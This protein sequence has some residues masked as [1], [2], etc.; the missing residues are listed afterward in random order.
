MP[1][2]EW[3]AARRKDIGKNWGKEKPSEPAQLTANGSWTN[4]L[5]A[6][7]S[8]TGSYY[9]SAG[10]EGVLSITAASFG[11]KDD[12]VRGALE[13]FDIPFK[14][15]SEDKTTRKGIKFTE[16]EFSLNPESIQMV[17]DKLD[18]LN[19][20]NMS[21]EYEKIR[22]TLSHLKIMPEHNSQS[23]EASKNRSG[24]LNHLLIKDHQP[25]GRE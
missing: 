14:E 9:L 10:E 3:E 25:G 6:I 13:Y 5:I 17:V 1:K 18:L 12:N 7:L 2:D 4:Q 24:N 23:A 22:D 21:N 8:Q 15:K 20:N 11:G 16:T 19:P